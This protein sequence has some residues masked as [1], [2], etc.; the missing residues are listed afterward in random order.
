MDTQEDISDNTKETIS[1]KIFWVLFLILFSACAETGGSS[2]ESCFLSFT[3]ETAGKALPINDKALGGDEIAQSFVLSEQKSITKIL[4]KLQKVGMDTADFT[5]YSIAL[6]VLEDSAGKPLGTQL[7]SAD[8]TVDV[9]TLLSTSSLYAFTFSSAFVLNAN[10]L[11][12]LRA[13]GTYPASSKNY[14]QWIAHDGIGGYPDGNAL[15][16][17]SSGDWQSGLIGDLSDL[18]FKVGCL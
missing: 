18:I 9:S 15:Y 13:R 8:A 16:E 1:K 7:N 6:R 14:I 2:T 3:S 11:Y 5:G 10:T 4:L 17:T 12:W